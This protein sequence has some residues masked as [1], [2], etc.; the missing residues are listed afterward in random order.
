MKETKYTLS[1]IA[2]VLAFRECALAIQKNASEKKR[3]SAKMYKTFCV[4]V[5]C[6]CEQRITVL[7][8][9][10]NNEIRILAST[11]FLFVLAVALAL[12]SLAYFLLL[13]AVN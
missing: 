13:Y 9:D 8:A 2:S 11:V 7:D 12:F 3:R 4:P 1:L 6:V 5:V 10:D